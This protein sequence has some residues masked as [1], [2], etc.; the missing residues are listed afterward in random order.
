MSVKWGSFPKTKGWDGLNNAA[1]QTFNSDII[2]S[3]VREMFQNSNDARQNDV[4][5][6]KRKLKVII[7]YRTVDKNTFPGFDQLKDLI[8]VM[9]LAPA[10]SGHR[11]FFRQATESLS[12]ERLE[13]LEF[14][15]FNTTGLSGDDEDPGSTFNACVLSEGLSK[16]EDETAGGSYGIGKNSIFG[17]SKIRT[18]L[19]SSM[20]ESNEFIFQGVTKLASYKIDGQTYESRMYYGSGP[21]LGSIRNP[22]M[23]SFPEKELVYRSETGLTQIAVSPLKHENWVEEFSKAILRNYWLLLY[24]DSLEVCLQEECETVVVI[25]SESFEFLLQRFFDTESYNP[26]EESIPLGN[27]YDYYRCFKMSTPVVEDIYMLGKIKFYCME[28]PHKNTNRIAYTRNN[29]VI[30]ANEAWGF[31]SI[32]YCGVITCETKKGNILL[33]MMEPPTHDSFDPGRLLQKSEE[34]SEKDGKRALKEIKKLIRDQLSKILDKYRKEAE[35]IPWLNDFLHSIFGNTGYGGSRK[36]GEESEEETINRVSTDT[37]YDIEF[38]SVSNRATYS[39]LNGDTNIAKGLRMRKGQ[40]KTNEGKKSTVAKTKNFEY[41]IFK[42]KGSHYVIKIKG[43]DGVEKK[44]LRL[45]QLGDSGNAN[46]FKIK[47]IKDIKGIQLKYKETENGILI[48][49]IQMPNE[50]EIDI[51]EPYKSVFSL[52]E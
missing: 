29:M 49:G 31:S 18:V 12:H 34:F 17:F 32:G 35:E 39:N 5:G 25:N 14:K 24:E 45:V 1:I 42:E 15:D 36:T 21:K 26:E 47:S 50:L 16:K 46:C 30:Q 43:L 11:P 7:N 6:A 19:Y 44:S 28:L 37:K 22:G 10:N 20:N 8:S 3:F 27:P 9:S 2:N 4:T 51:I 48:K 40:N 13:V 33:R 41:R 23:L 38:D 52:E